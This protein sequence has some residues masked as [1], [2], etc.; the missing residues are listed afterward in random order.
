MTNEVLTVKVAELCCKTLRSSLVSE[1]L[2][3]R[4]DSIVNSGLLKAIEEDVR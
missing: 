3:L 4:V 1:A 2:K